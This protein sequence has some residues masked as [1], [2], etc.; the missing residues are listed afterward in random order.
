MRP[1]TC[2]MCGNIIK[3][4]RKE[5][6][7]VCHWCGSKYWRKPSL[8]DRLRAAWLAF[9]TPRII[10]RVHRAY[11]PYP[12]LSDLVEPLECENQGM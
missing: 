1:I 9:T 6:R 7:K 2:Y 8:I 3:R 4:P 11:E 10:H 5:D 12:K